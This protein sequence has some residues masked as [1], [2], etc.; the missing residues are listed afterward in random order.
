MEHL[1]YGGH[2]WQAHSL[3]SELQPER[4][5]VRERRYLHWV[6]VLH[7]RRHRSHASDPAPEPHGLGRRQP[8]YQHQVLR[9]VDGGRQGSEAVL[10][11]KDV[12]D[13][14]SGMG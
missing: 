11:L 5:C 4:G 6:H 2:H 3:H 8:L 13:G 7:V 10:E 1:Q 12:A 9:C 14:P